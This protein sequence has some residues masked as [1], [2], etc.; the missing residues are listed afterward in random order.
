MLGLGA[1]HLGLLTDSDFSSQALTHRV[2]AIKLLN[3]S[4]GQPCA[5]RAEG[6][7]RFAT[8]MALTFQASYLPEGMLEFLS[9]VRGCNVVAFTAMMGPFEESLFASFSPDG[10]YRSVVALGS[11]EGRGPQQ[12]QLPQQQAE[13]FVEAVLG[14]LRAVGPLCR[15][16][17]E[18]KYLV[19]I[20]R[21][22]RL[23]RVSCVEGASLSLLANF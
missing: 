14:S 7:A 23:A 15:S 5:S 19:G 11:R 16:T 8:I 20:E 1:S 4:L 22:V 6:D 2:A 21:V 13:P 18:V 12:Q 17:T 10:H 9:M 3:R